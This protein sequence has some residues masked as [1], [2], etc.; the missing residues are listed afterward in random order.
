MRLL[1]A[2]CVLKCGCLRAVYT[3]EILWV[4]IK[5]K[6]WDFEHECSQG[7]YQIVLPVAKQKMKSNSEFNERHS[8]TPIYDFQNY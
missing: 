8:S 3:I 7:K 2:K 5:Y 4:N 6:Y 1:R